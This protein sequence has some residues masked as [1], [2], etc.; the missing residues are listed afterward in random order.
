M[1]PNILSTRLRRCCPGDFHR[2]ESL[3]G[4][5]QAE[6]CWHQYLNEY[7]HIFEDVNIYV[8]GKD[9]DLIIFIIYVDTFMMLPTNRTRESMGSTSRVFSK[10]VNN[11]HE[12]ARVHLRHIESIQNVV[13]QPGETPLDPRKKLSK[14]DGWMTHSCLSR[15]SS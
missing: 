4:F 12:L 6:R 9:G 2:I 10:C 5:S 8:K 1:K 11:N 7:L 14:A 13:M 15:D 3:N